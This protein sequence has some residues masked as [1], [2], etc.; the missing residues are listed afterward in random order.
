MTP[1]I[2]R[3]STVGQILNFVSRGRILPFPDQ[4]PGFVVPSRYLLTPASGQVIDGEQQPKPQSDVSTLVDAEGTIRARD[5]I[6][7]EKGDSDVKEATANTPVDPF[8]ITWDG[9]DDQD[10]PR[11][12]D[13]CLE[14]LGMRC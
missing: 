14:R 9:P 10:N 4:R 1:D 7:L 3:D 11:Y 12:D 8:L 6:D 5:S 2:F 13:S